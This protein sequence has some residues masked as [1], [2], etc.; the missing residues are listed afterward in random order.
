MK[1]KGSPATA[2]PVKA[3]AKKGYIPT[4]GDIVRMNLDPVKGHEQSGERPVIVLSLDVFNAQTSQIFICPITNT[5]RGRKPF[6]VRFVNHP[7]VTGVALVDQCRYVD[8]NSR[9][10]RFVAKCPPKI[11][12]AVV[13]KHAASLGIID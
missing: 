8:F 10:I 13:G 2:R 12:E 9:L 5:D 11:L 7:K 1:P 4:R 3:S 6:E